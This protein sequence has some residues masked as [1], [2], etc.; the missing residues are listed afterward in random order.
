MQ[1]ENLK[2]L[3]DIVNQII[4][5]F[6]NCCISLKNLRKGS[7]GYHDVKEANKTNVFRMGWSKSRMKW[8]RLT[9]SSNE[10]RG[11]ERRHRA[12]G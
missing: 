6:E 9:I 3:T 10:D 11:V 4:L 7:I 12:R 5:N 1:G 2:D 8:V